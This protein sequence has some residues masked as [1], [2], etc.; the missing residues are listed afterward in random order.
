MSAELC[1]A[2]ATESS[3]KE[4]RNTPDTPTSKSPSAKRTATR[5]VEETG[6][7]VGDGRGV[8][9]GSGVG[10]EVGRGVGDGGGVGVGVGVQ[11]D[12]RELLGG[13]V[14]VE[15]WVRAEAAILGGTAV[16]MSVG[17]GAHATESASTIKAMIEKGMVFISSL[18]VR[19]PAAYCGEVDS[20]RSR[21]QVPEAYMVANCHG[22]M[23]EQGQSPAR[24]RCGWRRRV[25]PQVCG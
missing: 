17:A 21:G 25:A 16:G 5:S 13:A 4:L 2:S 12:G 10:V 6:R 11:V 1:R 8:G 24:R 19:Y 22:H 3:G 9:E 23:V 18:L 7:G 15:V 14:R 20:I